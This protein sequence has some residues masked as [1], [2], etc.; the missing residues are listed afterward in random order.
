M[1]HHGPA[2]RVEFIPAGATAA[3]TIDL[4]P[5]IADVRRLVIG[6]AADCDLRITD[7]YAS[8]HHARITATS[9]GHATV[10]D[11]GSTNGTRIHRSGRILRITLPEPLLPGDTLVIG[12]TEITMN[13]AQR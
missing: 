5:Y 9:T 7:P 10:E 2:S 12:R 1:I 11:L 3:T 4:R 8:A 6:T 13:G